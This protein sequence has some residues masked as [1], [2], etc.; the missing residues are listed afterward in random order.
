MLMMNILFILFTSILRPAINTLLSKMAGSEQGFA[1]GMNNAYSSLGNIIGPSL[2]GILFDVSFNVPFIF[3]AVILLG[4]IVMCV[5]W[6]Q[7]ARRN[8]EF[9]TI[10]SGQK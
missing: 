8:S 10:L 2:A 3:G 7:K 9:V 6:N 4:S 1:A 5:A